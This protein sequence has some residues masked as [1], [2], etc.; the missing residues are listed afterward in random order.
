GRAED[1][2]RLPG[3]RVERENRR[4]ELLLVVA[5]RVDGQDVQLGGPRVPDEIANV[6][7]HLSDEAALPRRDVEAI[8]L[9]RQRALGIGVEVDRGRLALGGL[10]LLGPLWALR[11]VDRLAVL[12]QAEDPAVL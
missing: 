7:V 1:L 4:P 11:V 8:D 2:A 3:P 6:G 10:R 5:P 9:E 12:G